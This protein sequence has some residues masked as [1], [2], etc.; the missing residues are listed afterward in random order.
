M[1]YEVI[2]RKNNE[3]DIL[4]LDIKMPIMD[5]YEALKII[6]TFRPTL[7]VVAIT[8]YAQETDK[9]KAIAEGCV[10]HI[11]KPIDRTQLFGVLQKYL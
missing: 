9:E 10:A 3:I 1:L 6:K 2:T 8:A 11:T 5:G 4:L 7:P